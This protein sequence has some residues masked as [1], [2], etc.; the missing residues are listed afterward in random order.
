MQ[1]RM[2]SLAALAAIVAVLPASIAQGAASKA[3]IAQGVIF[4]GVVKGSGY[5]VVI[6][7]NKA[8]TKI[9]NATMGIELKCT[10]PGDLTLPD[11]FNNLP[12]SKTGKF[13]Y[14][15]GPDEFPS[16][17]PASGVSKY[18]AFGSFTGTVNRARTRITGT[19][20]QKI[21][22]YAAAD[23]TGATVFDTCDSGI[24]SFVAKQ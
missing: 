19:W 3:K 11:S 1:R 15:Y 12:V 21:V 18:Q 22:A 9:V 5:P 2:L 20:N 10:T 6:E 24:V 17:N 4:G 16:T 7:L 14:S 13:A 8:G 23:P